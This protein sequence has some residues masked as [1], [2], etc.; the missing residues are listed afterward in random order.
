MYSIPT[1]NVGIGEASPLTTLHVGGN[2]RSLPVV[3]LWGDDIIAEDWTATLGL[4]S[5]QS[6]SHGSCITLGE[7]VDGALKNKWGI[8]RMSGP[9]SALHFS[10][11]TERNFSNNPTRLTITAG[12]KVGI[13]TVDPVDK[14]HVKSRIRIEG[15][16]TH[17]PFLDLV[18]WAGTG[19]WTHYVNNDNDFRI[20]EYV[21]TIRGVRFVIQE[22][23]NVGIGTTSPGARLDV[24]GRIRVSD[25]D[26]DPIVEIGEGLDYAEGFDVTEDADIEAGTVLVIDSEN[27]GKLTVS[28]SAYDSKVAGIVAGANG[29]GSG[30]RLGVSQFDQDVA[31]AGRVYCKVDTKD[32]PVQPGD[33]LTTSAT[34]GYAM[35]AADYDRARGAILGKAME[36][37]E[38]GQKGQILVLVTLQ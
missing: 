7:F 32:A 19:R 33:L 16:E 13:G 22:G 31:L 34:A 12:G 6:A 29:M 5:D 9:S 24:A 38:K 21:G 25:M 20:A 10:F 11:G 8:Y 3:A 17:F 18:N 28:R 1:G 14:L 2:S 37:L 23:G 35:K 15:T 26:G 27:P 4:Y 36:S 30:V